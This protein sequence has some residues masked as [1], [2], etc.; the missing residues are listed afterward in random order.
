[1]DDN[2][3]SNNGNLN[4]NLHT[5][6]DNLYLQEGSAKFLQTEQVFY[7][8]A[9]KFNRDISVDLINTFLEDY[10]TNK[11][12]K[13][14]LDNKEDTD[15]INE[16][17]SPKI[18][19]CMAASGLRSIRYFNEIKKPKQIYIN[20]I[21]EKSVELIRK[22]LEINKISENDVKI[23]QK[24]CNRLMFENKNFFDIIDIDPFGTCSPFLENAIK[25][26]KNNGLL[27]LTATD[28]AVLCRDRVKCFLKYTTT[29][30]KTP[31][32][33]ELALRSLLSHVSKVAGVLECAIE[34]IC[35]IS[36]DFYVRVFVKIIKRKVTAK[37]NFEKNQNC[38]I[39]SNCNYFQK[40]NLLDSIPIRKCIIGKCLNK[41]RLEKYSNSEYCSFKVLGP[42]WGDK[43][44]CYEFLK[45]VKTENTR[46]QVFL[47]FLL[48]EIDSFLYFSLADVCSTFSLNCTPLIE[49]MFCIKNM[50]FN[51][52]LTHCKLNSI[53][54]NI[55]YS[56]LVDILIDMN[57]DKVKDYTENK[58][59]LEIMNK[60][61][62][63]GQ[64]FSKMGPL[65]LPKK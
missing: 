3:T 6:E 38:L 9:Q 57:G 11:K 58:E 52:S 64:L 25:S 1:M 65:S 42:V 51:V 33:H 7:N 14:H 39:C 37:K 56:T 27:I 48:T 15:N 63:K 29:I 10:T 62:N 20:D 49:V 50:G 12:N 34:P 41:K 18:L 8:P 5:K 32:C 2:K 30:K 44:N 55:D 53:K 46:V 36:V 23:S 61:P 35:S 45:K 28:T 47:N 24:D 17:Y 59:V 43:I 54:T 19:E 21:S 22:N 13:I 16:N 60:I 4:Q 26:V 40:N 31:M